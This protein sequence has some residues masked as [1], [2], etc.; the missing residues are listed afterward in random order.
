MLG[1]CSAKGTSCQI[2]APAGSMKMTAW[3]RAKTS[4]RQPTKLGAD[5]EISERARKVGWLGKK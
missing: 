5:V 2:T 3:F 4:S 1:R